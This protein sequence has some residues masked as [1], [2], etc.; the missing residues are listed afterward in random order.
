MFVA[1]GPELSIL[2]NDATPSL[3]ADKHPAGAGAAVREVWHEIRDELAPIVERP[4]RASRS[5]WTTSALNVMRRG[6]PEEAHFAFSY[7]PVRDEDGRGP[8]GF[9]CVCQETTAQVL[10]ERRL[11]ESEAR[12]RAEAE[13]VQLALD[14]G[15]IMGTWVWDLPAT[16]SPWTRGSRRA[17]GSIPRWCAEG[18]GLEQV[19]G[20]RASRGHAGLRA[21]IAE[22][23]GAGRPYAHRYRVRRR[24]ALYWIE[25]NGRVDLGPDGT[26][27]RFPG[28]LLDVEER[29]RTEEACGRRPGGST[30][31]WTTPARRCS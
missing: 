11:R 1:W 13:R 18:A 7:K 9:F 30:P 2:Y 6:Y 21:A 12:A 15:A 16:A 27:L 5:R 31:S 10:A 3:M 19:V 23:I 8:A 14:A 4:W 25:A 20:D 28:V 29:R 22:A 26:A 24:T 17:S